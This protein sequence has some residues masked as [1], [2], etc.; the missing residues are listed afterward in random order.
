MG[1]K[2]MFQKWH[3]NLYRNI[4]IGR[5]SVKLL[6]AGVLVYG[7]WVLTS[8]LFLQLFL[9]LIFVS[10]RLDNINS[11]TRNHSP[12]FAKLGHTKTAKGWKLIYWHGMVHKNYY[13]RFL[14]LKSPCEMRR[15]L[16]SILSFS[17]VSQYSKESLFSISY[18]AGLGRFMSIVKSHS[19]YSES[20]PKIMK[21]LNKKKLA[22]DLWVLLNY[23]VSV[24]VVHHLLS[25]LSHSNEIQVFQDPFQLR[26]FASAGSFPLHFFLLWL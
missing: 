4:S 25:S 24:L 5:I 8:D 15:L 13:F 9:N 10:F 17:T 6:S 20:S 26:R 19:G 7:F 1:N 22:I 16:L 11:T 12:F 2:I 18:E 21:T 23:L 14:S 3:F